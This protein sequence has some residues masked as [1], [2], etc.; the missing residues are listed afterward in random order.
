MQEAKMV[1]S[2]LIQKLSAET[3]IPPKIAEIAV[4][5]VFNGMTEALIRGD[6]IEIRG[7]GS[8]KVREY[9]G[10][11]G[12]HPRTGAEI[13]ISPKKRPFFKVGKELRERINKKG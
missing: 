4:N 5:T 6:G 2:E 9:K 11:N 13:Q 3:D 8:F 1:K 12:N 7:F 10:H